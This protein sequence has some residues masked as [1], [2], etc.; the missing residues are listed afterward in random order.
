[1]I[2]PYHGQIAMSAIVYSSPAIY[3]VTARCVSSTCEPP[4]GFH[5]EAV[6]R[7]FHLE[8]RIS[9]EMAEPAAD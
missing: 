9:E 7:I 8:R 2:D 3:S 1:M 4:L 5:R 6:D